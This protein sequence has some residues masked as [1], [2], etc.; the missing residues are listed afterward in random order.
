MK[1]LPREP[2]ML[3][4]YIGALIVLAIEL[5]KFIHFIWMT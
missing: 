2:H 3:L 4:L 1:N 5:Y